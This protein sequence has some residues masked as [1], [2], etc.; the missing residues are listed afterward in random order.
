MN[1]KTKY[2][3]NHIVGLADVITL[4]DITIPKGTMVQ[5]VSCKAVKTV[6]NLFISYKVK[7]YKSK[8]KINLPSLILPYYVDEHKL[9]SL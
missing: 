2:D 6:K 4:G 1:V 5:V 7:L 3:I 9:T 8:S